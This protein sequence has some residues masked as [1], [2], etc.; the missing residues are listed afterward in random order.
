MGRNPIR[1]SKGRGVGEGRDQLRGF[2]RTRERVS[3]RGRG[4]K[5]LLPGPL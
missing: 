5:R 1:R 4:L 2:G 3:R